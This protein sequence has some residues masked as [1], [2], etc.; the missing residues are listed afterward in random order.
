MRT[1]TTF[2]SGDDTRSDTPASVSRRSLLAGAAGLLG[3]GRSDAQTT[4]ASSGVDSAM[5]DKEHCGGIDQCHHGRFRTI[6]TP[7]RTKTYVIGILDPSTNKEIAAV[8]NA[9]N[10]VTTEVAPFTVTHDDSVDARSNCKQPTGD[11][12]QE[13]AK[14][15]EDDLRNRV[16]CTLLVRTAWI[17]RDVSRWS[18]SRGVGP[19]TVKVFHDDKKTKLLRQIEV[20]EAPIQ[21]IQ[22]AILKMKLDDTRKEQIKFQ[23][24]FATAYMAFA[25]GLDA[26][27]SKDCPSWLCH[28]IDI[29]DWY[30]AH[31]V[32]QLKCRLRVPRPYVIDKDHAPWPGPLPDPDYTAY[33][34]GHSTIMEALHVVLSDVISAKKTSEETRLTNDL[35]LRGLADRIADNRERAG[36][37]TSVDTD[38]GRAFGA[39]IGRALIDAGND[40]GFRDWNAIY[41]AAKQEWIAMP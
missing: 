36:L 9:K 7:P 14:L 12:L 32:L 15:S 8:P 10:L 41:K 19:S 23:D 25:L 39:E 38:A 1:T 2:E 20:A 13:L 11:L 33:P 29:V 18:A 17:V 4:D 31:T 16:T 27:V 3:W 40:P 35:H 6:V 34:G 30:A 21:T 5:R 28:L 26:K 37:H 24:D 22:D